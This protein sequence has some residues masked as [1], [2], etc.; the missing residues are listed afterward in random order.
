MLDSDVDSA[1]NFSSTP[2][3]H[4]MNPW[5][6]EKTDELR[7]RGFPKGTQLVSDGVRI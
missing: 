1:C 7:F 2:H 3:K 6:K 4:P 5:M